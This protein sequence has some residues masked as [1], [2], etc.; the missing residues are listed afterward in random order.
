MDRSNRS[1]IAAVVLSALAI[2]SCGGQ[3]GSEDRATGASAA[4]GPALQHTVARDRSRPVRSRK[5][6]PH[7]L[8]ACG[9]IILKE[10]TIRVDIAEGN[11]ELVTCPH[12]RKVMRRFI[13]TRR[14]HFKFGAYGKTWECY[15]SRQDGLGWD[16]HCGSDTSRRYVD[17]GAGRRW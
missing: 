1:A 7:F 11:R 15:K 4:S 5:K 3:P 13:S 2:I 12:A 10:R 6:G 9:R 17:I 14:K 16:Y 8:Q